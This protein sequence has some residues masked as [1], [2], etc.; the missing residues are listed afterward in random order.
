[1]ARPCQHDR[2]L[3]RL[4]CLTRTYKSNL[5][6]PTYA[7][8]LRRLQSIRPIYTLEGTYAPTK[9]NIASSARLT[10]VHLSFSLQPHNL[11]PPLPLLPL[12]A[13]RLPTAQLIPARRAL[14]P[15]LRLLQVVLRHPLLLVAARAGRGY[16]DGRADG[17]LLG[18]LAL[19]R[20][21]VG[22]VG[23]VAGSAED[24]GDDEVGGPAG[25]QV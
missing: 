9:T 12:R 6:F 16:R 20:G 19:G 18:A 2:G 10:R 4:E 24:A 25:R 17:G 7:R 1:M 13:A 11:L 5:K 15:R 23:E 3:D 21:R 14:P 22:E 8:E